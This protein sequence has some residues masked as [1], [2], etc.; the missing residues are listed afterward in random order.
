[1]SEAKAIADAIKVVAEKAARPTIHKTV[2]ITKGLPWGLAIAG[3]VGVGIYAY[4]K[5]R[6]SVN[7]EQEKED[8]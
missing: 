2:T 8:V 4:N 1:M 6:E 5:G 3:M 7:V